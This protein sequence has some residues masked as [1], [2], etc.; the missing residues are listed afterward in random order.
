[1]RNA[2]SYSALQ[3]SLLEIDWNICMI[4]N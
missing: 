2:L 4:S 3:Y 1:M